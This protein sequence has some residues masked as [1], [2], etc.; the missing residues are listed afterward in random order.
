MRVL[1]LRS[2]IVK[3]GPHA[4]EEGM[5][6]CSEAQQVRFSKMRC[7]TVDDIHLK[8]L[9]TVFRMRMTSK[10]HDVNQLREFVDFGLAQNPGEYEAMYAE[11][12]TVVGALQCSPCV[13]AWA[14]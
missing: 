8:R 14:H 13:Q 9:S 3:I 6:A 11:L 7:N 10:R 4:A 5:R 12:L 2:V 1:S